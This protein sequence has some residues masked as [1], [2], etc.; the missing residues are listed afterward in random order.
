[1]MKRLL[2]RRHLRPIVLAFMML[3]ACRPDSLVGVDPPDSFV[4]P[5]SIQTSRGARQLYDQAVTLFDGIF[6]GNSGGIFSFY[7]VNMVMAVGVFTD[8]LLKREETN[9]AGP[10]R[11]DER[12]GSGTQDYG[13]TYQ[14]FHRARATVQQAREALRLY[15]FDVPEALQGQLQSLEAYTVVW[16]GELFCS[17]IPLTSLPLSGP[18]V[19]TRG[20]TTEELFEI[21]VA[22]FDS[23][24]TSSVDSIRMVNLAR[25]G[26]GRALLGLGK[27]SEAAAAVRSVPT[28]FVY[29]ARY[30]SSAV[31][32][33]IGNRP[34]GFQIVDKEGINGLDWSVDP[35]TAITTTPL[36]AGAMRVT[37]KYSV[38]PG[39]AS[40][41]LS[42]AAAT[43]APN[44]PIR[45]A[46]GVEARLIEAEA[47]LND[48]NPSWLATLNMLR[49]SCVGTAAC[50]TAP[51]VTASALSPLADPGTKAAREDL[52][53]RERA[54]WLY[55]T[56]H[57]QG[58]LRRLVRRY[59]RSASNL[60][61]TG[62]YQN[63]G[64]PPRI[65]TATTHGTQYGGDVVFTP[66]TVFS[67]E[68]TLNPLYNGCLSQDP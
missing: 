11:V 52:L 55:L 18:A 8:E 13:G 36:L 60:W 64:F 62:V 47:A 21:A 15:G 24:A 7:P 61:P 31:S 9:N 27:F 5:G 25:V 35:R 44:T 58:D 19:L 32:N 54:M 2:D 4:D 48:G 68:Q 38:V 66:N 53:M 42:A 16:F 3:S 10:R 34:Q 43:A 45:I 14:L 20:F 67:D 51:G 41:N 33:Y 30:N 57:R 37:A 26:K 40:S 65:L 6:G 63:A 50:A 29:Y 12:T 59:G 17:G 28:D 1:M 39:A 56:G 46:D 49:A 23:A 22:L